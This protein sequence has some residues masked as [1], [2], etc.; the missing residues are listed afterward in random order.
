[1]DAIMGNK[2]A[3]RTNYDIIMNENKIWIKREYFT[4]YNTVFPQTPE[5]MKP[6]HHFHPDAEPWCG[7]QD[8]TKK[9]SFKSVH[10]IFQVL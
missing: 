4:V 6:F 2:M 9:K 10:I 7:R 8:R 1:M 5:K 3:P